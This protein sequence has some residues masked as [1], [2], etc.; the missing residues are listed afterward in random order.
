MHAVER[1]ARSTGRAVVQVLLDMG[2]PTVDAAVES[3]RAAGYWFGGVLPRYLNADAF[4][5]QKTLSLPNFEEVKAD[6]SAARDLLQV[7]QAD[8]FRANVSVMVTAP[9]DSARPITHSR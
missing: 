9:R 5:M 4:L 2:T 6:S 8:W 7:V 3:L 1:Q